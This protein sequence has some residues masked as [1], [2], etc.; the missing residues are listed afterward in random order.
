MPIVE[1]HGTEDF[2]W[3]MADGGLQVI[4]R[5][6]WRPDRRTFCQ[7]T[8]CCLAGGA[9]QILDFD[10]AIGPFVIADAIGAG[11]WFSMCH[12]VLRFAVDDGDPKDRWLQGEESKTP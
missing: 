1:P 4:L 8:E 2:V 11:G 7:A 3:Q 12:V 6:A 9:H 10:G 5:V